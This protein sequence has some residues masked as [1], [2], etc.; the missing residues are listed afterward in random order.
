MASGLRRRILGGETQSESPTPR[1]NSPVDS[2]GRVE[3]VH[4]TPKTRKRRNT[5]IFFLGSLFGLIAAGLFA[6]SNDLID[7]PEIGDLSVDSFLDVLPA[8]LVADIRDLIVSHSCY[9][10]PCLLC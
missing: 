4:R 5:A 10:L 9:N 1:D 7:F 8:G 3:V 2:G 6:K